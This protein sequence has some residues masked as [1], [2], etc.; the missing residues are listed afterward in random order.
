MYTAMYRA[1]KCLPDT[2]FTV[3][4]IWFTCKSRAPAPQKK[5]RVWPT[6]HISFMSAPGHEEVATPAVAVSV[7]KAIEQA[8]GDV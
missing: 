4:C 7:D 5:S 2:L 1:A 6:L 3:A 8:A